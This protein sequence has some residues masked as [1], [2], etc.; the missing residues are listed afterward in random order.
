M[1]EP[2]VRFATAPVTALARSDAIQTAALATSSSVGRRPSAV[3]FSM[4][5][6]TAVLSASTVQVSGMASGRKQTTRIPCGPSS[7]ARLR[8][9]ASIAAHAVE[10]PPVRWYL[11]SRPDNPAEEEVRVRMPPDP[12]AACAGPLPSR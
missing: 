4:Y 1:I 9:S 3:P 6:L 8:E 12:V 5:V 10:K 2:Q 11:R 7:P